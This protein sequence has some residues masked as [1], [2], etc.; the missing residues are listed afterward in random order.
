MLSA[1]DKSP[2]PPSPPLLPPA[3]GQPVTAVAVG[4]Y[5][6]RPDGALCALSWE[7]LY[8]ASADELDASLELEGAGSEAAVDP[9]VRRGMLRGRDV[10]RAWGVYVYVNQAPGRVGFCMC[11]G[12][13]K[14]AVICGWAGE[15]PCGVVQG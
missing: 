12:A 2:P 10:R 9:T 1:A 11:L 4:V 15:G 8:G 3:A 14:P 7:R 5:Y 6:V 13:S